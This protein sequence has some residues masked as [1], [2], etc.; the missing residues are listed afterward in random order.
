MIETPGEEQ[1]KRVCRH[2]ILLLQN[3]IDGAGGRGIRPA[4]LLG[5]ENLLL[6]PLVLQIV[7]RAR[8]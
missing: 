2:S 6:G 3:V 4:W 1:G 7:P 5:R 8:R